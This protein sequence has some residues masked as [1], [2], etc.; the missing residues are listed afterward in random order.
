[1]KRGGRLVHQF[2]GSVIETPPPAI[3][4]AQ[5]FFPG[6]MPAAYPSQIRACERAGLRSSHRSIDDYRPTLRAWFD[7][8]VANRHRAIELVGVQTYN[9]YLVFFP[10]S[11]RMFDDGIVMLARYVLEKR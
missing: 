11:T 4:A 7:N 6:S 8:L 1:M 9:K 3:I 10:A 2:F 5:S